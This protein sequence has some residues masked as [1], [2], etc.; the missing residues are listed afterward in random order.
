MKIDFIKFIP[1]SRLNHK[2][3]HIVGDCIFCGHSQHMYL[4]I[5]KVYKKDELGKYKNSGDCKHCGTTF[6]LTRLLKK[7]GKEYLL[8]GESI[9][10]KNKL[11]NKL[12]IV[13]RETEIKESDLEVPT[14]KFPVGFKRVFH[15]DYLESRNFTRN[16]FEKYIVGIIPKLKGYIVIGVVEEGELKGYIARS[17][18]SKEEIK[19]INENY[20]RK[21]LKKRYLRWRNSSGT[22][23]SDL[24]GGIDEIQYSVTTVIVV[25]GIFDKKNVDK[26]LQLDYDMRM[27][28]VYSFG[29]S[30]SPIQ[31]RKIKNK[32]IENLILI[33]DPDAVQESKKH[34]LELKKEFKSVLIGYTGDKDLGES[35]EQE[36]L[37]VFDNLKTP[38]NYQREIAGKKQLK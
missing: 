10:T 35:T 37:N 24:V 29:K 23:F 14:I 6:N 12:K 2:G 1:N 8:E 38:Q 16:D 36:V 32:G 27:K 21:G 9:D 15:D 25:E 4:N 18:L 33:Q 13:E 5:N 7:L 19:K 11:V 28:C 22:R 26:V 31:I 30:I 3:D 34:S 17:R 20:K